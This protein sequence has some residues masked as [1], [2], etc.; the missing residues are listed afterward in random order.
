MQEIIS[1][2][3]LEE[4]LKANIIVCTP[5]KKG[6]SYITMQKDHIRIQNAFS[7][8]TLTW[9]DF[10]DLYKNQKFYIYEKDHDGE[11]SL[12]KDVEYYSWYHK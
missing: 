7:R 5:S 9:H 11:I 4:L 6:L 8:Y 10:L 12:E 2:Q 1:V 3:Q